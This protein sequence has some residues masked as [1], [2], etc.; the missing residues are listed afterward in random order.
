MI[1]RSARVLWF[2]CLIISFHFA[3]AQPTWDEP[4]S[5]IQFGPPSS[6]QGL[7]ILWWNL[8]AGQGAPEISQLQTHI[9]LNLRE[10]IRSPL[11][12]DILAFTLFRAS[13]LDLVLRK[14]LNAQYPFHQLFSFPGNQGYGIAL[15]SR[16]PI[17]L[18][19]NTLLDFTPRSM[20]RDEDRIQY[21]KE[22]CVEITSC[23]RP[24]LMFQ[25]RWQERLISFVP[26]HLYDV[27]R[28][29]RTRHGF[30]RTVYEVGYGQKNA[31]WNQLQE[32]KQTLEAAIPG[33]LTNSNLVVVGD[34]NYPR[35][36]I[37]LGSS[38]IGP[39]GIGQVLL[40]P[41]MRSRS[42]FI[43]NPTL[44]QFLDLGFRQL[45]GGEILSSAVTRGFKLAQQGLKWAFDGQA[46]T[47]PSRSAADRSHYPPMH[48]D[49]AFV[50]GG[51]DVRMARVL[52]LRG[53]THYPFYLV[54]NPR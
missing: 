26:V 2:V 35:S 24:F 21:R 7:K 5:G 15:F 3:V 16:V 25:L 49:H 4:V 42:Q 28:L 9:G 11:A 37:S 19:Q 44:N 32:F 6:I 40:P 39:A 54:V 50:G 36:M 23:A 17:E 53:S 41:M 10:L 13:V 48:I 27:W 38:I 31:L 18:V 43:G 8:S 45:P 47:F 20:S 34:F 52:P 30:V 51:I 1:I 33:G 12:P 29:Y 46:T 22:W 14:E